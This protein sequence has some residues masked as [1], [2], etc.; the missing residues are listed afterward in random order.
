[1][2]SDARTWLARHPGQ[3]LERGD[4]AG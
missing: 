3:G 4:H 2:L 1:V